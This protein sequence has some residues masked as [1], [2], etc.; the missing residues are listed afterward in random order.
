MARQEARYLSSE[1]LS[2][3]N[4]D[5]TADKPA[6]IATGR[7]VNPPT[8]C[9]GTHESRIETRFL[10]V[11]ISSNELSMVMLLSEKKKQNDR[12]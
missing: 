6:P 1:H 2:I 10:V 8:P 4:R 12:I 5:K 9:K 7:F 11:T 3:R